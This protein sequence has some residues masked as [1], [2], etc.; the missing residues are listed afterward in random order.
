MHT[1]SIHICH[2]AGCGQR[3][4]DRCFDC[5]SWRCAA[6]LVHIQLPTAEGYFGEVVCSACLK[7]HIEHPDPYGR[8]VVE[9]PI[10]S[11]SLA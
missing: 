1:M 10:Q 3:A 2:E 7:D 6:H 8:I 4:T 9:S 11:A 5:G